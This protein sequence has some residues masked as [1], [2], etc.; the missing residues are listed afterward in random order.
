MA[1]AVLGMRGVG[2]LIMKR[3]I[4]LTV[5]ET[6]WSLLEMAMLEDPSLNKF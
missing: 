5:V 6:P 2:L 1:V 3:E 4:A